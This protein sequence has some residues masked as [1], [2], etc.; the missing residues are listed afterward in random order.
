[1]TR[2]CFEL[3]HQVTESG[4]APFHDSRGGAPSPAYVIRREATHNPFC[5]YPFYNHCFSGSRI[6][7]TFL[8]KSVAFFAPQKHQE[9]VVMHVEAIV[10]RRNLTHPME[11]QKLHRLLRKQECKHE[12]Q[13]CDALF[14]DNTP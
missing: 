3:K 11:L 7:T 10:V 1:M 6:I 9:T 4:L 14:L 13:V 8:N 12:C 2:F 5:A